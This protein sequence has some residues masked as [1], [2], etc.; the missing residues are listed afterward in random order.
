MGKR[1]RAVFFDA[2]DTLIT[3]PAAHEM[4]EAYLAERRF[5]FDPKVVQNLLDEGIAR[6]YYNKSDYSNITVTPETDRNFWVGIY[7]YILD[8]MNASSYWSDEHIHRCCHELYD[9]FVAPEYYALFEDVA[10]CLERLRMMGFR[11]GLVSN[12][13]PTLR[14]IF[15]SHHILH[16]FDPFIVS[17]EVGYEKPNPA[18]FTMALKKA[19]LLS[20][21]VVYV[22][23]HPTND[24][25]APQQ[26]GIDAIRIIRYDGITGDGIRS[27]HELFAWIQHSA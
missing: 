15:R 7:R 17:T 5:P 19:N 23:D 20:N 22:G 3:I 6:F 25:W 4:M 14:E 26:V 12:F 13:A 9:L 21:E 10:D 16:F 18:I 2:G 8:R 1:Y 27:L 24:I 11:L